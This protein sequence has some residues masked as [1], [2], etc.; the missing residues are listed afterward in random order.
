MHLLVWQL[1]Q[2]LQLQIF[3]SSNTTSEVRVARVNGEYVINPTFE[4]MKEAD[5]DL[6]VGAN[7]G[8]YH[9]GR[10]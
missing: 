4:Q 8:Q 6:M 7:Q 2:R 1:L 5:M 9:D 3:Q 10:G